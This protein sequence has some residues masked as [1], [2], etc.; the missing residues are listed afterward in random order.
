VADAGDPP[1]LREAVAGFADWRAACLISSREITFSQEITWAKLALQYRGLEQP[2]DA[3][4]LAPILA[5][6]VSICGPAVPLGLSF[7]AAFGGSG[8]PLDSSL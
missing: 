3:I 8:P 2:I 4:N 1:F 6:T 7:S 5:L